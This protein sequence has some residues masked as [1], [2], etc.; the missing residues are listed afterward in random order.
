MPVILARFLLGLTL[1][2]VRRIAGG[3]FILVPRRWVVE[4]S[5]GWLG[6]W[7]RLKDYE[8]R[9]DVAEAMVTVAAIRIMVHR[10]AHPNRKRLPSPDF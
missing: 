9:T 5:F 10:L 1:I 4:R 8:E 3:G 6:R 2:I 7:R